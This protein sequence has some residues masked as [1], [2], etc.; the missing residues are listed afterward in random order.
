[1]VGSP[2]AVLRITFAVLRPTPGRLSRSSRLRGTSPPNFSS[3]IAQVARMFF[4]LPRYRP[5]RWMKG[6]RPASPRA[7]IAAGVLATG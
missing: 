2:K 5:M 4:A 1:M 3:R 6:V 7:R